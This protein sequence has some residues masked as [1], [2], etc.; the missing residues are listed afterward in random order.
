MTTKKKIILKKNLS[1]KVEDICSNLND[2]YQKQIYMKQKN[3]NILQSLIKEH[4]LHNYEDAIEL[5]INSYEL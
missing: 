4:N 2:R 3:W 1:E 5:L